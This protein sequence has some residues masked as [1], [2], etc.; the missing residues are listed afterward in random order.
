MSRIHL[1]GDDEPR[2]PKRNPW[3]NA[4]RLT[5]ETVDEYLSEENEGAKVTRGELKFFLRRL[6]NQQVHMAQAIGQAPAVAMEATV[7][8]LHAISWRGRLES[9]ARGKVADFRQWRNR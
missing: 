6:A 3:D 7:E 4:Q 8:V 9:W 1:L 2:G 5:P